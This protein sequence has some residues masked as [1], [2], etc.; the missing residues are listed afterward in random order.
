[1][2]MNV[3]SVRALALDVGFQNQPLATSRVG[4]PMGRWPM[5]SERRSSWAWPTKKVF[6]RIESQDG[7]IGW[8]YTNGGEVVALI[9][10]S[11]FA[12]LATNEPIDSLS[13]FWDQM[14]F[15]I[16]PVDRSGFAMMAI[17][18]V[19]I[20]LWDLKAKMEGKSLVELLGGV[21][22]ERL[23]T[24]ATTTN[25]EALADDGWW[26]L[27]AAMPF[28]LEGGADGMDEN[29]QLMRRFRDA[30]GDDSRIM[31]D[32]YMSWN[33]DYTL[34]FAEKCNSLDLYWIEDPLPPYDLAGFRKIK[35]TA[36]DSIR[37]AL[38]NFCFSRWDCELLVREGLVDVLQPDVA[39][40][41]GVT[42]CLRILEM[43][44][45]ADIPVIL[46]N[47]YEQPWAV[48]LAGSCQDDLIIE[49]VD[50]GPESQ[51][52]SLMGPSLRQ[53]SGCVEVP[54][55]TDGNTPPPEVVS[56]FQNA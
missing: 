27:K 43:A 31:L 20:A 48:A 39:W 47:T 15:S 49:F 52:Y 42:E 5:Y 30:A 46:H 55:S 41:G 56:Q 22:Q 34:A 26:G 23:T 28:G 53:D 18:A 10:E 29:V 9:I 54:L 40:A 32:S 36:G 35:E 7:T 3:I 25:P 4:A 1:M 11:Q 38:G 45:A 12:R 33:A 51:I 8:S 16:L 17:A 44:E 37:L 21:R 2:R 13:D 6:V 19:D 14:M 24:Y 50:R